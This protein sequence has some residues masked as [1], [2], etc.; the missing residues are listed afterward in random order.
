MARRNQRTLDQGNEEVWGSSRRKIFC[1]DS[2]IEVME[3]AFDVS[4]VGLDLRRRHKTW[5]TRKTRG[6]ARSNLLPNGVEVRT[7]AVGSWFFGNRGIRGEICRRGGPGAGAATEHDSVRRR[8]RG[9]VRS[10]ERR[11]AGALR[12]ERPG[13]PSHGSSQGGDV[14]YGTGTTRA[15]ALALGPR[16]SRPAG[17]RK[18]PGNCRRH[19]RKVRD[20]GAIKPPKWPEGALETGQRVPETTFRIPNDVARLA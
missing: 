8:Q 5:L 10:A 18:L 14:G 13:P 15:R 11:S 19:L 2:F 9:G 7:L 1:R 17:S 12:A 16:A 20:R 3:I 6:S 4:W